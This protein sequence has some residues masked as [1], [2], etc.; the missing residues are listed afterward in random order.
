MKYIYPSIFLSIL[1]FAS[2]C[3]NNIQEE[4][5]GEGRETDSAYYFYK[6]AIN[7]KKINIKIQVL[8]QS[9]NKLHNKKDTLHSLLL[10]YKIYYHN[11]LN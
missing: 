9:L 3:I 5:L 11:R 8:N 2:A 7:E 4:D 1:F 10:D 6:K